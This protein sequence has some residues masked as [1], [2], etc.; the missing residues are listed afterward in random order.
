M[1]VFVWFG[2]VAG[3]VSIAFKY[4]L[5]E[6]NEGSTGDDQ[7]SGKVPVHTHAHTH[8]HTR[9]HTQTHTHTNKHTYLRPAS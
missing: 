3:V 4:G 2:S 5:A 7:V 1:F 9:T 6:F 8:T